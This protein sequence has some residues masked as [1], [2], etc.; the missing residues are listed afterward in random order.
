M[1]EFKEREAHMESELRSKDEYFSR[2]E[3]EN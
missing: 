1:N 3:R 2:L